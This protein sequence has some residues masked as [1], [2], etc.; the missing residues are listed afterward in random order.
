MTDRNVTIARNSVFLSIRMV[1]VLFVSLYTSRAFLHALGVVDYGINN[2]V[3]GFVSMFSFLNTALSNGTQRFYNA[4]MQ[5]NGSD[6]VTRVYNA[7]LIIQGAIALIIVILLETVGLWYFYEK[8]VIPED[9]IQV[10]FWIFQMSII[11]SA[12]VVMTA[13]FSGAVMAYE[14]MDYYALVGIVEV[15]LK[16]GFALLI[17]YVPTDKLLVMGFMHLFFSFLTFFMFYIYCKRKFEP[18]R[19]KNNV[20][21]GLLRG[22]IGFSGW[23]CFGTVACMFREQGLNMVLNLFFG[24]VVNAARG[25]A[26]QVSAAL[27]SFVTNLSVAAKPQMISSFAAGDSSH[28]INLMYSMSKLS[29]YFLLIMAIPVILEIDFILHLWLGEVVP[30]HT[31]SFVVLVLLTNFMNNLNAPLSNV[32]YATGKMRNYELTF[33]ILNILILP[34]SYFALMEGAVPE[35]VFVVYLVMTIVVQIGCLLVLK[36]L[37]SISLIEY[38]IKLIFPIVIVGCISLPLPYM[39]HCFIKHDILRVLIVTVVTIVC[40]SG[41]FYYLALA[42]NERQLVQK[43]LKSVT[44]R[45]LKK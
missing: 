41:S 22:M 42:D 26:Y 17:P 9:R 6:G 44:N 28:T 24:P 1:I 3:S 4:E 12:L 35:T 18:I 23:N 34:I 13:P 2:V 21:R 10:A 7:S 43:I 36:T 8:M 16:L 30:E 33:S 14:K 39:A 5:K 27:Q 31:A 32:V 45:V 37:V 15:V 25:I 20:E 40:S 29:F 19:L 38:C 11:S